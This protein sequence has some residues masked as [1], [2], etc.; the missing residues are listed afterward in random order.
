M[1]VYIRASRV[2]LG[3]LP[4][5]RVESAKLRDISSAGGGR[6]D[7]RDEGIVVAREAVSAKEPISTPCDHNP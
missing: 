7:G 6:D 5:Y 1:C 3:L 4:L 2:T